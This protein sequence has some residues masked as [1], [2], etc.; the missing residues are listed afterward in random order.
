MCFLK[1]MLIDCMFSLVKKCLLRGFF[2]CLYNA[3][4]FLPTS[5]CIICFKCEVIYN[6]YV[7]LLRVTIQYMTLDVFL[8]SKGLT[9]IPGLLFHMTLFFSSPLDFSKEPWDSRWSAKLYCVAFLL[10]FLLL[11]SCFLLLLLFLAQSWLLLSLPLKLT[12]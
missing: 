10:F 12:H 3:P 1:L 9:L 6:K 11:P 2:Q 7:N 4:L 8:Q 5:K